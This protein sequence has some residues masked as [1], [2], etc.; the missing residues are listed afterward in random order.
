M[1][2]AN[3]AAS[4]P[5]QAITFEG[6]GASDAAAA[7]GVNPWK[8]P[9]ELW[10][11]LQGIAP[12]PR[13]D[14]P[15]MAWGR[16][17]E[18]PIR[19]HYADRFAVQVHVP[20]LSLFR[21]DAPWR[22]ASPDGLVVDD[23]ACFVRGLEIKTA[24]Q[25]AAADWG[26]DGSD[27]VPIQYAIQCHWGMHV[28]QIDSWDLAALIGG[29]DFRVYRLHRDA[30]LERDLVA[31]VDCFWHEHVLPCEPPPPDHT[32]AFRDYLCRRWPDARADYLPAD[33]ATSALVASALRNARLLKELEKEQDEIRNRLRAAIGD[34][35]GLETI[36]G[37]VHWK[38]QRARRVID[39]EAAALELA[40]AAGWDRERFDAF[41]ELHRRP[42][43]PLRPLRLPRLKGE[44]EGSDA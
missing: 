36:H 9:I 38:P 7:A 41:A 18:Q 25:Y 20:P 19:Q 15:A 3:E 11:Q 37:R 40:T 2:S 35:S 17:L 22:R 10:E 29:R 23:A 13:D 44:P 30:E 16:M 42:T 12:R 24:S 4:G 1:S 26:P 43:E 27:E 32:K 28:C 21:A 33:E 34:W 31:Q 39:W 8:S 5:S 14:N 6:I